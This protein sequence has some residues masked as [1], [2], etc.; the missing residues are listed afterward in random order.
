MAPSNA[1]N[2]SIA[3]I[4]LAGRFPG[5][6]DVEQFWH[7]LCEGIESIRTLTAE[8]LAAA[9]VDPAALTDPSYVKAGTVVEDAD[10]FDAEFFGINAR[11]A[12]LIDPQ[13]RMFLE[14]AH[15][16]L[17]SA[18]YDPARYPGLIGVYAGAG[19]G[20]YLAQNLL[21][22]PAIRESTDSLQLAIGNDKDFLP[23]RLSYKLNLKGPSV[24]VQTACSTS[25]VAVHLACEAL[26]NGECDMALAGGVSIKLP[27]TSG[28]AYQPDGILSPDG[29]CRAFDADGRGTVPGNGAALVMLKRVDDAISDRDTILAVIRASAINNDGSLKAGY[30]A[31]SVQGQTDVIATAHALAGITAD[32]IS[33]VEAHGTGTRVGD[34]IEIAALTRAFRRSTDRNQF[35]AIGSVK[36]NVGHMDTAAGVTGLIKSVLQLHRK[37]LVPSLNFESPNAAIDFANSPFYVNTQLRPWKT[38]G[39]PLRAAISS[40]GI[41]GTNAHVVL[42]EAPPPSAVEPAARDWHLLTL[43]AKTATALDS[44]SERLATHLRQQPQCDLA[45][46][47]HTLH[48]GRVE[49]SC[50]RA[51]VCRTAAEAVTLLT[52]ADPQRVF[53]SGNASDRRSVAFMFP[54]GGAQYVGMA[55]GIYES[56]PVFRA[57]I[58]R[59]AHLLSKCCGLDLRAAGYNEIPAAAQELVDPSIALP[60][61]FTTEYALAQLWISWGI[62]PDAMI[63]HSLGEYVAACLAGVF[64]LE[65]A[66]Q[67]VAARGRLMRTL[68]PGSMLAVSLRESQLRSSLDGEPV[69]IAA[70]NAPELCVAS[71]PASAIELLQS[72]LTGAG[73]DCRRLHIDV[74][75]HCHTTEAILPQFHEVVRGF[76]LSR[77]SI[78]YVSNVTGTWIKP[79]E[80]TDPRYWTRHLRSTVRFG[81]GITTLLDEPSRVLLEIGPGNT[82]CSLARMHLRAGGA[83]VAVPSLRAARDGQ[84]DSLSL[85][86]GLARLWAAGVTVDWQCFHSNE[87]RRRIS[88]PT[89]PFERKRYWIDPVRSSGKKRSPGR[90]AKNPDVSGWFY[91]PTWKR[92]AKPIVS[93][94]QGAWVVFAGKTSLDAALVAQLRT[95]DRHVV[96]VRP[97]NKFAKVAA[98]EYSVNPEQPLD[99]DA[100]ISALLQSGKMPRLALHLWSLSAPASGEPE[101]RFRAAQVL[102]YSSILN[103]A[104]AFTKHAGES[105][106][107]LLAVSRNAYD[108]TGEHEVNPEHAILLG[109]CEVIPQEFPHVSCSHVD[110][111]VP[112][113]Q[114]AILRLAAQIVSEASDSKSEMVVAYRGGH[115]WIRSFDPT[116]IDAPKPSDLPLRKNGV[117]LLT[118]G[119][120]KIGLLVAEHLARE[121]QA[122]LI[123]VGRS[124]FPPRAEW[125]SWIEQREDEFSRKILR[126]RA[127]EQYGAI[128][129]IVAADVGDKAQ[130]DEVT[131]RALAEFGELNGVFHAA[132]T[133]ESTPLPQLERAHSE[134]QFRAKVAGVYALHRALRGRS[135]DFC[136]LFSSVA[137]L[138]GGLGFAAYASANAFMD[139]FA[140]CTATDA[141]WVAVNWEDWRLKSDGR[142]QFHTSLDQ[143]AMS[144]EE[145]MDVLRRVLATPETRQVVV[146]SAD[147]DARL[148]TYIGRR[149][150]VEENREEQRH[151]RPQLRS[152]YVAPRDD[153]EKRLASLWQE[154]LGLSSVGVTDSFFD[155]GGH[156]LLAVR[157]MR[158]IEQQF[159]AKLPIALLFQAPTIEALAMHVRVDVLPPLTFTS[160]VP[161]QPRGTRTPFFCVHGGGGTVLAFAK[162][163]RSVGQDQPVYGLQAR[164]LDGREPLLTSIEEMAAH[165]IR[166]IRAVQPAG[167]YRLGGYSAGGIIAFEMAQQLRAAGEEVSLLALLDTFPGS[168]ESK[169]SLLVK[170]LRLPLPDQVD[171]L[172]SKLRDRIRRARH[173]RLPSGL[174]ASLRDVRRANFAAE[175]AYTPQPYAGPVVLF[176]ATER[177]LRGTD[178]E[179]GWRR[180]AAGHFTIVDVPG[181][182]G[183]I[184]EEPNVQFL[185][186]ELRKWLDSAERG[187]LAVV[188]TPGLSL[189]GPATAA[190]APGQLNSA[191]ARRF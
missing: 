18:G 62:V 159:G 93:A 76:P 186:A 83:Q 71:G 188:R 20:H 156:S 67:I 1:N 25:L 135:V 164:G 9:G 178:V 72:R 123:L 2:F 126:I 81:D 80:A 104:K 66:L 78:P 187:A 132:G 42:E 92:S 98:T 100:L 19:F 96:V 95:A 7:N 6:A 33:Y 43:S 29:H 65:A 49:H 23:T 101:K 46:A 111:A 22:N 97:A 47:A 103:F 74:A 48:L 157:M 190:G 27:Q 54:G 5:A 99:Y 162:L 13:H 26:L 40:F 141:R 85:F 125:Q 148:Q 28:Y 60:A 38:N 161:M 183:T 14:C 51:V 170:F 41:G 173:K 171:Y 109:P 58:D 140:N 116:H 163:V 107:R 189:R 121:F 36:T 131:R 64:S 84:P 124:A 24:N 181:Q 56:E 150:T 122:R 185:A 142:Q 108:V 176:R 137:S 139:A 39:T 179:A 73:V 57:E 174:P 119:L 172:R 151:D 134:A 88:L 105:D 35:C 149:D 129:R 118:G 37:T 34:P 155:L 154:L 177:S 117:Y 130:I 160:L 184:L 120:G 136:L 152:A 45:D 168:P 145:A 3:V 144:P 63:G 55:R 30:T 133:T 91:L 146:S 31:P 16:A 82:L 106:L 115:R 12:E 113:G 153:A 70:A 165:Y 143:L 158:S 8:E 128:V 4:A 175:R 102:G 182:H 77:P 79:E 69:C 94:A 191:P 75:S 167:P 10:R 61:L 138:L 68:P 114:V 53:S 87:K 180:L 32:T 50:R 89:Y 169:L 11:E 44:A 15:R 90:L 21:P 86:N 59:C 147:L 127:M 17:E 166:D 52:A 112:A 110:V